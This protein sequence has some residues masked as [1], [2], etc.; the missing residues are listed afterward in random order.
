M[1]L[2]AYNL[3]PPVKQRGGSVTVNQYLV[4]ALLALAIGEAAVINYLYHHRT[5]QLNVSA[6][7]QV[8]QATTLTPIL[9]PEQ[10]MYV[11]HTFPSGRTSCDG[12]NT[13]CYIRI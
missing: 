5:I 4:I 9:T 1:G 2:K 11:M 3:R 12:S 8:Q 7:Q 13:I 6:I 10:D